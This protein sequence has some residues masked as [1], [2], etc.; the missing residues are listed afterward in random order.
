MTDP[1]LS[2]ARS[3]DLSNVLAKVPPPM[4]VTLLMEALQAT[5]A[6]EQA[7]SNKYKIPVSGRV[8]NCDFLS[9]RADLHLLSRLFPQF[10]E[11]VRAA[12]PST[13]YSNPF[14]PIST[15]FDPYLSVYVDAQDK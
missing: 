3:Q 2:D 7:M 6:F 15:T 12:L 1:N 10:S 14:T 9:F 13:S 5:L 11:I 4:S 8:R